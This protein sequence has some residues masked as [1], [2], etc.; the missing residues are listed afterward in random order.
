MPRLIQELKELK[1]KEVPIMVRKWQQ[2]IQQE[3]ERKKGKH[4]KPKT[5]KKS[6]PAFDKG[7]FFFFFF[8]FYGTLQ[9]PSTLSQVLR[10][11]ESEPPKLR[12]AKV[13]GYQ[14][15]TAPLKRLRWRKLISDLDTPE[16]VVWRKINTTTSVTTNGPFSTLIW[17][18]VVTI[19]I[20][21]DSPGFRTDSSVT[22]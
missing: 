17:P 18:L 5:R 9:D 3:E 20:R 21:M 15:P 13:V 11:P 14:N 2:E 4:P 6:L 8:F 7:Y 10:L 22:M 1:R 12:P 19:N 16:A